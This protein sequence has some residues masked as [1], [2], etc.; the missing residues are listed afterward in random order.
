[1]SVT[2]FMGLNQFLSLFNAIYN[3]IS[4]HIINM[5]YINKH[6]GP[7]EK[8]EPTTL[9]RI[10]HFCKRCRQARPQSCLSCKPRELVW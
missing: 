7:P 4:Y 10:D 9:L 5:K 2:H 1:M 6:A 3:T 8:N